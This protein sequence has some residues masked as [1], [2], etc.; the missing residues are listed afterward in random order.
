MSL[1]DVIKYPIGNPPTYEQLAA[2]PSDLYLEWLK[3]SNWCSSV[4]SHNR[5]GVAAKPFHVSELYKSSDYADI[6]DIKKLRDII[7]NW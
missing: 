6:R 7:H 1:F 2:L 5:I 4:D 3:N